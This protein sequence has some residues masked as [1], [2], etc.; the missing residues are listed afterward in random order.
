MKTNWFFTSKSTNIVLLTFTKYLHPAQRFNYQLLLFYLFIYLLFLNKRKNQF[1]LFILCDLL[2]TW[3][4]YF[5]QMIEVMWR[6]ISLSKNA[7]IIVPRVV[8]LSDDEIPVDEKI[9]THST[10]LYFGVL[11]GSN[12]TCNVVTVLNK[13]TSQFLIHNG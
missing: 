9:H 6:T 7:Q 11:S 5:E 12:S 3:E 13:A 1:F 4:H 10:A 2:I 8:T